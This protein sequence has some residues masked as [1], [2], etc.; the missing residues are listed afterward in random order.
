MSESMNRMTEPGNQ[1]TDSA[2]AEWVGERGYQYWK[3][4]TQ[5]I[6]EN[7]PNV[8]IPEWL[9]G[10]KKHGWSL[11]YKKSKS[12]CTLIPEKNRLALLVVFGAEEREKVET[13]RNGLSKKTQ[14][15][16][17]NATTYHDGKWLFLE[18]DAD[19]VVKDV[20]LLLSAKRRPKH[21]KE[22]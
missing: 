4:I 21:V 5:L 22:A 16:Y 17:D 10:G 3:Q 11:R 9:Y 19:R 2:V 15:E 6:A 20:M 1:P 18:I 7:Y 14:N 12:F 8:F 13:I